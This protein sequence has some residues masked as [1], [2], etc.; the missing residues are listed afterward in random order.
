[1]DVSKLKIKMFL[2][3]PEHQKEVNLTFGEFL[4]TLE[5]DE[6]EYILALRRGLDTTEIWPK[7]NPCDIRTNNYNSDVLEVRLFTY[8]LV[9]LE[10]SNSYIK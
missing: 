7:R 3:Q 6:D 5:M 8:F 4:A 2:D 9:F 1:M 10:K